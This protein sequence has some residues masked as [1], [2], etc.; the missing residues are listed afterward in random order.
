M[1]L[2]NE[3]T[4]YVV[5]ATFKDEDLVLVTPTTVT[6]SLFD[7]SSGT[8]ILEDTACSTPSSS[9]VDIT[10]SHSQNAIIN[11]NLEKELKIL[12]VSFTYDGGNK[13]GTDE[14]RYLVKN[15]KKIT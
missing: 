14:H 4:T 7:K 9:S 8:T 5:T 10:I 11:S 3:K 15:L 2:I 13:Q 6:Y 1:D 12:T